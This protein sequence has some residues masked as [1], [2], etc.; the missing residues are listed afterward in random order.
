LVLVKPKTLGGKKSELDVTKLAR[1]DDRAK[2]SIATLIKVSEAGYVPAGAKV[3]ARFG[4]YLFSA[5]IDQDAI[6]EI[7]NDPLVVSFSP[8][9][10]LRSPTV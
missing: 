6:P 2:T 7:E 5:Q 1:G 9:R 10:K 4:P 8:A 3:R